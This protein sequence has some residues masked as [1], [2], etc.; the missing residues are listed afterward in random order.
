MRH[1]YV[2]HAKVSSG[3]SVDPW[4]AQWG[5]PQGVTEL[6]A[7]R[8]HHVKNTFNGPQTEADLKISYLVPGL[9]MT[10]TT[11]PIQCLLIF[12][13]QYFL[14]WWKLQ[15]KR[16]SLAKLAGSDLVIFPLVFIVAE[17]KFWEIK[18]YFSSLKDGKLNLMWKC[19]EHRCR[20]PV[21]HFLVLIFRIYAIMRQFSLVYRSSDNVTIISKW[22]RLIG[23]WWIYMEILQPV[24]PCPY[25]RQARTGPIFWQNPNLAFCYLWNNLKTRRSLKTEQSSQPRTDCRRPLLMG[26]WDGRDCWVVDTELC[27]WP[28]ATS[29]PAVKCHEKST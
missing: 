16:V 21:L 15:T 9:W 1:S 2:S 3:D 10:V 13:R 20:T 14:E 12:P 8:F 5:G 23:L 11:P 28:V 29:S 25:N 27:S 24:L 6:V 4:Q 7:H 19:V 26:S 17:C 18:A 22:F